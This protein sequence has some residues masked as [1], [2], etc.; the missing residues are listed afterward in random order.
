MSVEAS[1]W[2]R[3]LLDWAY[4]GI[5]SP[6]SEPCA[7][8]TAQHLQKAY[9]TCAK[10]ARGHS[11]TFYLASGLLPSAKCRAVRALYAFCRISDDIVDQPEVGGDP[12]REAALKAW[13]DRMMGE[14]EDLDDDLALAWT[15]TQA[16]F[17]IPRVYAQQLI[18]GVARDLRQTRYATFEELTSYCY[19]VASTVGLM[20][21]HIVGFSTPKALPYAVKL[22]VA[23]QLTNILRDV[24]E[25]W[26][27]GRLYLPQEELAAFKLQEQDIAN[28]QVHTRWREFMR[29]QINR[30]RDLYAE[31]L[32]GVRYLNRD[33]RFAIGAAAELYGAILGDIEAHDMD[34]FH[35]RAHI[36]LAGKLQRLPGIWWR[37]AVAGYRAPHRPGPAQMKHCTHENNSCSE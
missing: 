29:F 5:E 17:G 3:R 11:R 31:S 35:R 13:R 23:L 8:V 12:S 33:G 15:D 32:I 22:G 1:S 21:M 7:G 6:W 26:N 37:A 30:I 34:V 16:T 28:G 25:D 10:V 9:T 4:E 27:A 18:D 20:A 2:E 14:C 36:P 24:G 19:G